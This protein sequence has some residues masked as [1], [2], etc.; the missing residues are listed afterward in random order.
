MICPVC[1]KNYHLEQRVTACVQC[2]TDLEV[3]HL[4]ESVA[5][6]IKHGEITM[7][8]NAE[9]L[10]TE[11]RSLYPRFF[12]L[13]QIMPA[14][15]LLGCAALGIYV[16]LRFLNIV[17]DVELSHTKTTAQWSESGFEQ[18]RQMTTTIKQELDLIIAQ[19]DENL[20]LQSQVKQLSEQVWTLEKNEQQRMALTPSP[21]IEEVARDKEN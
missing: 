1:K 5:Q 11:K 18:L 12:E 8:K 19:R 3:H 10:P 21:V 6:N 4:L 17:E 16:G 15:L 9:T 20:I 7:T 13:L 14:I 2:G